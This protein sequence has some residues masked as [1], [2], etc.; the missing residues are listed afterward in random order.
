MTVNYEEFQKANP[1]LGMSSHD[2]KVLIPRMLAEHPVFE[3]VLEPGD[4]IV[5]PPGLIHST[6]VVS[7]ECSL[8]LS[9][10]V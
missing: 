1:E 9:L 8:S 2:F 7:D 6:K 10:Q 4:Q 3:F 5:F